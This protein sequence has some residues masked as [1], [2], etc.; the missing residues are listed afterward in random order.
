LYGYLRW[1]EQQ[2]DGGKTVLTARH[3]KDAWEREYMVFDS[4][5]SRA[6]FPLQYVFAD[7]WLLDVFIVDEA[8][9]QQPIRLWLTVLLDAYSRCVLGMALLHEIP[10]QDFRSRRK[11][12]NL[13]I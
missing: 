8:T 4:F 10:C 13:C 7:H 9:R 1:F 3:G 12:D 5:V 2:A 6:A 11:V